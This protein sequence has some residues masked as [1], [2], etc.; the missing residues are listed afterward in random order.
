MSEIENF[1][2]Q[3]E[4][5][6]AK[7]GEDADLAQH[8]KEW[9]RMTTPHRYS[10]HFSWMGRPIIQFPQDILAMQ[11]LVWKIQPQAIVE[12]GVA[13]GGSAV[14]YAS[15]L[16]L[17]GGDRKVVAVD[18]SIRPHNRVAIESH[19]MS[20]RIDLV[21]GS[22]TESATVAQVFEKVGSRAPV[23]VA[24]DSNHSHEHVLKE[25]ELYSP[26]VKRGSYLVVFDTIIDDM[27][28]AFFA[29]RPWK[30]GNSPRTAVDQFLEHNTRFVRDESIDA[31]LQL[32]V[33][34]GG[35]L[36][37]IGD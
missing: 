30:R 33:A 28:D 20:R 7:M 37:C 2:K 22:S 23:I 34:P 18:I 16:E 14:L 25:L 31:K 32:S 29:D 1:H 26:L 4:V 11:E 6:I 21:E 17:L 8:S 12:T 15:L 10:Y 27:P 9:I 13:H 5:D 24:L 3:N 36:K 35:Y 19:P